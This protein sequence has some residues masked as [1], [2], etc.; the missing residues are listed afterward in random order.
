[1]DRSETGLF[2]G[3]NFA[4][5]S[6][7]L[8]T[9]LQF[10]PSL[11]HSVKFEGNYLLEVEQEFRYDQINDAIDLSANGPFLEFTETGLPENTF[12]QQ[13]RLRSFA[14]ETSASVTKRWGR[15][16]LQYQAIGNF[17]QENTDNSSSLFYGSQTNQLNIRTLQHGVRGI[18]EFTSKVRFVGVLNQ[19]VI[20]QKAALE[21]TQHN[22]LLPNALV[23]VEYFKKHAFSIAHRQQVELPGLLRTNGYAY[24]ENARFVR[25]HNLNLNALTHTASYRLSLLKKP[26]YGGHFYNLSVGTARVRRSYISDISFNENFV[27]GQ[28]LVAPKVRRSFAT[29]FLVLRYAKFVVRL[30][31][32][33]NAEKGFASQN[34]TLVGLTRNLLNTKLSLAS[35]RWDNL[36]LKFGLRHTR[37]SQAINGRSLVFAN[38][39]VEAKADYKVKKWTFTLDLRQQIQSGNLA[40]NQLTLLDLNATYAV[41][42]KW[43]FYLDANNIFNLNGRQ[44][45]DVLLTEAFEETTMAQT[46]PGQVL[47]GVGYFF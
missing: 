5:T 27:L 34:E 23:Y 44:E 41:S 45:V 26:I 22:Y 15:E 40:R 11:S 10:H 16:L 21:N 24:V 30:D 8:S 6:A 31:A 2:G 4:Q 38:S 17:D 29:A 32:Q 13:T 12:S 42:K 25:L 19:S 47:V 43:K 9:R 46:F 20:Q 1:M 39:F 3:E 33:F 35:V 18:K 7:D 36:D 14:S 37:T 28:W